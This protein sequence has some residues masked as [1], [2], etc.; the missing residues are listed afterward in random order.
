MTIH[1]IAMN[2]EVRFAYAIYKHQKAHLCSGYYSSV[3][4]QI[5]T[6]R[7]QRHVRTGHRLWFKQSGVIL[8]FHKTIRTVRNIGTISLE[9]SPSSSLAHSILS[10]LWVQCFLKP[11]LSPETITWLKRSGTPCH[12]TSIVR[13]ISPNHGSGTF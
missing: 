6:R 1:P 7:K 12:L 8:I 11:S 4:V 5:L 2:E 13:P 10:S 3:K 9:T